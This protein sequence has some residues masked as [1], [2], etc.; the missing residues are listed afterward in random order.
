MFIFDPDYGKR[1]TINYQ[2]PL[3]IHSKSWN[4]KV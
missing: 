3:S 4:N 1:F 2:L